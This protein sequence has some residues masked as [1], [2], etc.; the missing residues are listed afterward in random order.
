[1][2]DSGGSNGNTGPASV[3][4]SAWDTSGCWLDLNG[5]VGVFIL[6]EWRCQA[7]VFV[8]GSIDSRYFRVCHASVFVELLIVVI[9]GFELLCVSWIDLGRR[10]LF[11]TEAHASRGTQSIS[12]RF[13]LLALCFVMAGPFILSAGCQFIPSAGCFSDIRCHCASAS[14]AVFGLAAPM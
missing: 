3:F 1:M 4:L 9:F 5:Y 13:C 8:G 10:R 7:S 14:S 2:V 11:L 6:D 12:F